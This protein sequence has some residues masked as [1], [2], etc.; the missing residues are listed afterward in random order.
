M[1]T[2]RTTT[3]PNSRPPYRLLAFAVVLL[4]GVATVPSAASA[5]TFPTQQRAR[6]C[7]AASTAPATYTVVAGDSWFSIALAAAITTGSLLASNDATASSGLHPGDVLC[8]PGGATTPP[9]RPAAPCQNERPIEDGD[10]WFSIA[11][12]AGVTMSTLVAQNNA[13]DKTVLYVGDSICLPAGTAAPAAPPPSCAGSH[14]VVPGD[15]WFAI[16]A[17]TGVSTG[18]LLAANA[19][20]ANKVIKPGDQLCLPAGA[21]PRSTAES[22]KSEVTVA[23]GESWHRISRANGVPLPALYAANDATSSTV[24]QPGDQICLPEAGL[25][26]GA[27]PGSLGTGPVGGSCRF[28]N[29]WGASRSGG[30]RQHVGVDLLAANGA[31]VVAVVDGTLTRQGRDQPGSLSGNA[32]RLTSANGTYYFYAHLAGFAPGLEVGS[33]VTAGQVIGHVGSSGN[34]IAPHLHFEI[35]PYGGG[36]V[37]P[38]DAVWMAGGCVLDRR[39]E[40]AVYG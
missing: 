19:A 22:C 15:S 10:S 7:A 39:Y 26:G 24:L 2:Y 35:H 13:T 34:A 16:A 23:A 8:L 33:K 4:V 11:R 30:R 14:T 36:P 37:N 6:V 21:A 18:A 25:R 32:W 12:E 38:Y 5:S 31:P 29:S 9:P 20:S 3:A 40:Q 1:R 27:S 28:A 17:T